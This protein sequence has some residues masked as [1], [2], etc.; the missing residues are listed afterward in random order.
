VVPPP[1]CAPVSK[2]HQP[3]VCSW[4]SEQFHQPSQLLNLCP[5]STEPLPEGTPPPLSLANTLVLAC[6]GG[7]LSAEWY[8]LQSPLLICMTPCQLTVAP[9]CGGKSTVQLGGILSPSAL[10]SSFN[11]SETA[12]RNLQQQQQQQQE[13]NHKAAYHTFGKQQSNR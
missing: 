5:S 12:R 9:E 2:P 3:H 6:H 13:R 8:C 11:R 1:G 4:V 10:S 7:P